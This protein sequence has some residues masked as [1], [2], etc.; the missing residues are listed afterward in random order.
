MFKFLR[1][2]L[3]VVPFMFSCEGKRE[4]VPSYIHIDK[5]N[6]KYDN[7]SVLGN[8]GT[9]ITDVWVY[10][11]S[12]LLGV[13]ELPATIAVVAEG[14]HTI[15]VGGGIKLNGI[16]ATREPYAFYKRYK[17]DINLSPLDTATVNPTV[18]YYTETG[19]SF[20][21][22]FED[23]VIG[24]DTTPNS[25]VALIRTLL[26]NQPSYLDR[27]AG[28]ATLTASNPGFKA[29]T[30]QLFMVPT[31]SSLP[32]YLELD[33]K[34]NQEFTVSAVVKDANSDVK[35]IPMVT[36]RSTV[37]NGEMKWKHIYI[38]LTDNF[39]GQVNALGF[40]FSFTAYY[41]SG[42]SEGLLYLDNTKVVNTK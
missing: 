36:L 23:V 42:N 15:E 34:C 8:G 24:I 20:K 3:L 39:I 12:N 2:L 27:Y 21:E 16:S 32:I 31:S 38:D 5:V 7:V 30:K 41:N 25:N 33:Y 35:E 4:P 13:F 1:F 28:L 29:Y 18:S 14:S 26:D 10:D 6:F 11:N 40:G 17:T 22:E 37:V 9:A 19:I